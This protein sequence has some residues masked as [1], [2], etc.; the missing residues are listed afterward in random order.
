MHSV[1]QLMN[2]PCNR[3]K[4]EDNGHRGLLEG[5]KGLMNFRFVRWLNK[6]DD[7]AITGI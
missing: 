3:K 1:A 2:H 5:E 6:N 7:T 4:Q